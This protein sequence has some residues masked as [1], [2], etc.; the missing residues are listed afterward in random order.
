[1]T[2]GLAA[3]R[4]VLAWVRTTLAYG[5]CGLL[6]ARLSV[7][8]VAIAIV[9]TGGVAVLTARRRRYTARDVPVDPLVTAALAG[10]VCALGIVAAVLVGTH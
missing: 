4:T 9:G 5:I 8:S 1:M 3:E 7:G 2:E 6:C 10:L